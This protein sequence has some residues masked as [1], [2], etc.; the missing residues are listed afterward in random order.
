MPEGTLLYH[1]RKTDDLPPKTEWLAFDAEMSLGIMS[2]RGGYTRLLTYAAS[3]LLKVNRGIAELKLRGDADLPCFK[4]I[5]LTE[6]VL[7]SARKDGSTASPSSS[8]ATSPTTSR[9][10]V[11]GW[12]GGVYERARELNELGV[13]WRFDGVVR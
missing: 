9:E 8:T 5:S 2:G 6:R 3:R 11:D 12:G 13:E 1:D 7:H 10:K 4:I